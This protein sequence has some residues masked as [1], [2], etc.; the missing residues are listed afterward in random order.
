MNFHFEMKRFHPSIVTTD[1]FWLVDCI[2]LA[3]KIHGYLQ[4]SAFANSHKLQSFSTLCVFNNV[5]CFR[6]QVITNWPLHHNSLIALPIVVPKLT[7]WRINS[8][9]LNLFW[10]WH[11]GTDRIKT[12]LN[13]PIV[14]YVIAVTIIKKR[15][16]FT[17]PLSCC[18][19]RPLPSKYFIYYYIAEMFGTK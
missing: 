3:L 9:E 11:F 8:I 5:L 2:Y 16:A 17:E 15:S 10:L 7:S 12:S 19:F 18:N 4:R 6:V 14:A 13:G 1:E